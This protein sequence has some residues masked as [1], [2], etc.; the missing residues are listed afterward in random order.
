M[1]NKG[2]IMGLLSQL[3]KQVYEA[4]MEL[5]NKGLVLYNFGNVSG[6]DREQGLIAIKPS[7]VPYPDLT[8]ESI[9]IVDLN[10][11][12]IEGCTP[13]S[14]TKTHAVLY[15]N[16]PDIGGIAHTHSTYATAWAQAM[17]PIPC[18]G[19]THADHLPTEVPCTE[20]MSNKQIQGDY[21]TE[22]G[23]QI[24]EKFR[25]LSYVDTPMA[26]VASHGPFTWGD[27]PAISVYN[28]V[29]LEEIAKMASITHNLNTAAKNI[30]QALIHRH[31][32]R[33]HGAN[34]SYG[35]R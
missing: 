9:V 35:Q 29:I 30:S 19:T 23:I 26:L 3:R 16:F 27:T 17:K 22:T 2:G 14:D 10:C 13:S 32:H 8:P 20:T 7:G 21:E 4:N 18:L 11:A 15:R 31:Y 34:A 12:V 25:L 33:K 5:F 1:R 24:I 6:I 28:G